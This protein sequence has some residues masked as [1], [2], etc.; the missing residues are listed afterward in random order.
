MQTINE[1]SVVVGVDVHKYGHTAVALG[2][3]GEEK[4]ALSFSN[5][6]LAAYSEWLRTLAPHEHVTV[7]LEDTNGY[8]VHLVEHLRHEGFRIRYVPA[9]LTERERLVSTKRHKSDEVDA[10][11]IG[12]VLLTKYGETQP[13]KE[14]IASEEELDIARTLDLALMEHADLT[15]TKTVLK[16][17][18]HG[19]LHQR[20]TESYRQH[21]PRSFSKKAIRWFLNDLRHEESVL[22]HGIVRRLTRLLFVEEQLSTI[23]KETA[24][25]AERSRAAT[26]L[27]AIHGCGTL[28]ASSILAECITA[29]RFQ[30]KHCFSMYAG[31]APTPHASGRK[32]TMRT[33]P[34]GNRKLNKALHTIALSQI[35]LRGDSRGKAYYRKKL[36]EGKTKLWALRC[37]KHQIAKTVY[38][39]LKRA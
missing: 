6:T 11:R 18:L 36:E 34:F 25:L 24:V 21:C 10:R 15:R 17:Q 5:S 4:G 19:L 37:L 16:N 8:G 20:Y 22:A 31:V 30:N 23:A 13:A 35:A 38:Q 26:A 7:G 33:N 2:A 3:W 12:R 39:T 27:T 14:S 9:I 32:Q 1:Q 28:T 29:K